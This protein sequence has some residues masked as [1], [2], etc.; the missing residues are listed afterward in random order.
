MPTVCFLE[1]LSTITS[2]VEWF[3][4]VQPTHFM[5]MCSSSDC[6]PSVGG[7][8]NTVGTEKKRKK[9]ICLIF[10]HVCLS[11][12]LNYTIMNTIRANYVKMKK[13]NVANY[14]KMKTNTCGAAVTMVNCSCN[15]HGDKNSQQQ[16]KVCWDFLFIGK[17][18]SEN[19][20]RNM[21]NA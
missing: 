6:W 1:G 12:D 21:I 11:F 10:S 14:V 9:K 2:I 7:N 4:V 16:L 3:S 20:L 13:K 15:L 5:F 18:Y 19:L 17:L 8:Q